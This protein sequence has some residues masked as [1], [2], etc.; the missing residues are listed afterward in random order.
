METRG[1]E[2]TTYVSGAAG[3]GATQLGIT[4]ASDSEREQLI[5]KIQYIEETDMAIVI[6]STL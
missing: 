6:S 5:A 3:V 2:S 1:R 4:T